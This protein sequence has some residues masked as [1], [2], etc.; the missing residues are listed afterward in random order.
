VQDAVVA[1]PLDELRAD[2]GATANGWLMQFQ[3]DLLGVPLAVAPA[4]ETTALGAGY[5]AGLAAGVWSE[6]DLDSLGRPPRR[7]EPR[8]GAVD[9]ETLLSEWRRAVERARDWIQAP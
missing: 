1:R 6:P 3:A 2:G 5:L 4:T 8:R 9:G 7:Y